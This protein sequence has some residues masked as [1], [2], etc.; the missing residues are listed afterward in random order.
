MSFVLTYPTLYTNLLKWMNRTDNDHNFVDLIPM[1]TEWARQ[2]VKSDLRILGF[3]NYV[4]GQFIATDPTI[5]KP[6][7][8]RTSLSFT[9]GGGET[10]NERTPILK[11][12]YDFCRAYWPDDSQTGAP[13]FYADYQYNGFLIVPTPDQNYNFELAYLSIPLPLDDVTEENWMTEYIPRT[14]FYAVAVEACIYA[15]SN[16]Q[17]VAEAEYQKSLRALISEDEA[18][19]TDRQDDYKKD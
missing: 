11:R 9:Y 10:G 1:F 6:S 12:T 5:I 3:D 18:Q 8:W 15:D 16:R 17:I 13:K 4:N 2:R 14:F 7:N 19:K